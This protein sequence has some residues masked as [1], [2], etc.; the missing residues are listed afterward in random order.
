M[1]KN[2][3]RKI[4][5]ILKILIALLILA[6]LAVSGVLG[7]RV[8]KKSEEERAYRAETE[9]LQQI[10]PQ[11][12]QGDGGGTVASAAEAA[13]V[14]YLADLQVVNPDVVAWLTIPGTVI[15]FPVVQSGDNDYY[16]HYNLE[17]ESSRLGVPFLDYRCSGDF[18]DFN[19]VIYGHY[20]SGGKMFSN[21]AEFRKDD[22][23][24]EHGTYTLI[25]E[26]EKYTVRII[27]CLI[28]P[29]DSFV[30]N[31]VFLTEHE[32][33][34][35]LRDVEEQAVQKRDFAEEELLDCQ[36]I[37]LSTCAYEYEG[38]RTVV[39]GYKTPD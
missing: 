16:L 15:D 19:S 26:N 8:Y 12:P 33:S 39:V 28:T 17:R 7:V 36:L 31:T 23:F 21:L 24:A 3:K 20:I 13:E 29:N 30:Y 4:L 27:A 1:G 9:K 34:V 32:K 25:T 38:A 5:K 18:S 2:K 11:Y 14:N 10:R 22:F 6:F 35:F 37:T